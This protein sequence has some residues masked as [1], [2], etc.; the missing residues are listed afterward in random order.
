MTDVPQRFRALVAEQDG[1]DVTRSLREMA[2]DELPEGDVTVRVGWSSVN[3]KDALAVS[4]KG[5]VARGYPLVPGIDLAGEVIAAGG[6]D[7]KPGDQVIVHGHD[8]GVAHHGG[9]AEVARV[10]GAWV[11]RCPRG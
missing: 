10:P 11:S 6:G 7:V 3:Y 4:P 1:D 8:L 9:F 2:A 5:R